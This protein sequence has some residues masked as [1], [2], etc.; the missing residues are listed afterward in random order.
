M[1]ALI[2][3]GMI[4]EVEDPPL[5]LTVPL[6]ALPREALEV[7]L[8]A[9]L[10]LTMEGLAERSGSAIATDGVDVGAVDGL[11]LDGAASGALWWFHWW[12]CKC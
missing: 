2:P 10:A 1:P 4:L 7:L 3:F 5:I 8:D 9:L 12:K 6:M 11:E